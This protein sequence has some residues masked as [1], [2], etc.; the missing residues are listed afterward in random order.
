MI[1]PNRLLAARIPE[2]EQ[3]YDWRDCVLYSLGIGAGVDPLDEA[4]LAF[5]DEAGRVINI[6]D[7]TPHSEQ[8]HCA[9]RP[10]RYALEMNQGWFARRG[11]KPGTPIYGL[12]KAPAAQ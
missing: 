4:D 3:R 5:L 2:V 9:A 7:M 1:D 8:Q 10:A 6:A 12:H 11:I